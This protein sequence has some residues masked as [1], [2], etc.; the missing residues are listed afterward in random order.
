MFRL[1]AWDCPGEVN[2]LMD[3]ETK[4]KT[5]Q[6]YGM[7]WHSY[8][9]LLSLVSALKFVGYHLIHQA[10][11]EKVKAHELGADHT[12]FF[13]KVTDGAHQSVSHFFL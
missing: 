6:H 13:I 1:F 3:S 9:K 4:F 8:L 2:I 7:A 10:L 12:I 11:M 5:K